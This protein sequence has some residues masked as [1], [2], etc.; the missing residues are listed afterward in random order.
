[1]RFP[2][3]VSGILGV[4]GNAGYLTNPVLPDTLCTELYSVPLHT[5]AITIRSALMSSWRYDEESGTYESFLQHHHASGDRYIIGK[6]A[7][8]ATAIGL[9]GGNLG[10]WTLSALKREKSSGM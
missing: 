4:S 7:Q 2:F 5:F 9:A 1:M 8:I 6:F 3:P 10:L